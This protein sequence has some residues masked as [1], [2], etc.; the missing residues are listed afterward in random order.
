MASDY[1]DAQDAKDADYERAWADAPPAFRARAAK[2]GI[3][4]E[5][6]ARGG[7]VLQY[8]EN[9]SR[10]SNPGHTPSFYVPDMAETLDTHV[11]RLIEKHGCQHEL[12][13]RAVVEDLKVPMQKEIEANRASM[14]A[15]V[16]MYLI[17]SESN[18]ILA[19]CHQLM[20]AIP[21]LAVISGYPSMR[22]SA[23]ACG[24]SCEWVRRGRDKAC[25]MLGLPIPVD[26]RKSDQARERYA[27]N[28]R[29]NH[30]RNQKVKVSA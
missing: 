21:R 1:S 6:E 5:T 28:G 12:L 27:K 15:R 11:D 25:E 29:E 16:V 2:L 30:W 13:I 20:H 17:K 24:V 7:V 26:G 19:R 4:A 22:K 14:L 9:L 3:K 8:D 18:N 10:V 23:K